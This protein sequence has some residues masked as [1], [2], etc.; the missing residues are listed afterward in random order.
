MPEVRARMD[1]IGV[2]VV[3]STPEQLASTLLKDS[4][5]YAKMIKDLNIKA[6]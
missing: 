5:R 1:S 3:Q 6:D 2:D 4:E